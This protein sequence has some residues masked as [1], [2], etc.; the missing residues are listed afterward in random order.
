[1]FPASWRAAPL[2]RAWLHRL[3]SLGV[4]FAVRHRWTGWT[5][6][7]ALAFRTTPAASAPGAAVTVRPAATV[8]ALGGASWP[9]TGSDGSW[10]RELQSTGVRVSPLGP[11]NAG[12]DVAWTRGFVERFAGAPLKN[13]RVT[14]GTASARG[15]A[16]VIEYGVESGVFY[17]LGAP[18]R[19]L[20]AAHG[21]ATATIDLHPD[22]A[23]DELTARLQTRR[24]GETTTA[25]L[26][27]AGGLAPVAIGLLREATANTLPA[28]AAEMAALIKAVP[29]R[30][31]GTQPLDRA[32]STAGGVGLD[33]IDEHFMLRARPGVFVAGEMLD[34]EAPT[35]GYLLQACLATGRAAGLGALDWLA[36]PH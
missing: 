15:E 1:V 32:I 18:L 16:V 2:L 12:F 9:R 14:A 25:W 30:L 5:D 7:G 33:E 31:T 20:I 4:A 34:W 36:T 27:R 23:V 17:A 6:D 35:G 22:R 11:A 19:A 28:G 10:T 29:L 24:R 21:S 3:D 13:L 26:R 8:L